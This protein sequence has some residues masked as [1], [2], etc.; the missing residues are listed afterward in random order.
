VAPGDRVGREA[1]PLE[2]DHLVDDVGQH[3]G[4][5]ESRDTRTDDD[6]RRHASECDVRQTTGAGA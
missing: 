3:P 2:D 1:L 5:E 4:S 6:R